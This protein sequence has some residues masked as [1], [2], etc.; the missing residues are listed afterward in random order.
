MITKDSFVMPCG[1]RSAGECMHGLFAEGRALC[2]LVEAFAARMESELLERL[3]RGGCH[4]WDDP[5]WRDYLRN[6]LAEHVHKGDLV[7]VANIA[8]FLWNMEQT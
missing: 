2:A 7:D 3:R 5:T 6:S 1:C 4:G 8:A